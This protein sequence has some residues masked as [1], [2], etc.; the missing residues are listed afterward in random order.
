MILSF[1]ACDS[2]LEHDF[3]HVYVYIW[4]KNY[5]M[6]WE[7]HEKYNFASSLSNTCPARSSWWWEVKVKGWCE[8]IIFYRVVTLEL[9]QT[10]TR[11]VVVI[12]WFLFEL[13]KDRKKKVKWMKIFYYPWS[14]LSMCSF[15]GSKMFI[16]NA[17]VQW[18][19]E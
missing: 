10:S 14:L 6:E 4:W 15:Q 5:F 11:A 17:I 2:K 3:Q 7:L 12:I 1:S 13:N 8:E 18:T 16:K 19:L 9:F